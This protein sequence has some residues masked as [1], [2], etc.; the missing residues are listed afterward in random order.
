MP[1]TEK[2]KTEQLLESRPR[3]GEAEVDTY[4]SDIYNIG[5]LNV[6]QH[7]KESATAVYMESEVLEGLVGYTESEVLSEIDSFYDS[8]FSSMEFDTFEY[9][10]GWALVGIEDNTV[11]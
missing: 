5:D 7:E 6:V 8:K 11:F 2:L 1:D 10:N 9:G 4:V 3:L